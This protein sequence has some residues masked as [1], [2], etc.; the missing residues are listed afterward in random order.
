MSRLILITGVSRGLGRAL[1]NYFDADGHR[2]FGCGRSSQ[3][4][5]SL[6][7]ESSERVSLQSVDVRDD[8]A[9]AA[10]VESVIQQAGAPELL[11][12]N[13]AVINPNAPLWEIDAPTFDQVIDIN[14]KGVQNVLRHALPAMVQ[15]RRGVIVNLSSGWG[16]STSPEVAPYC[17]TKWAIEGLTQ[18]L[19]Q[20]LPEGMAAVPLNPGVIH[21]AMLESCFGAA[22]NSYEEATNW[23]KRAAPFLLGLN[24]QHNGQSLSVP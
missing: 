2:V 13:A 23:A 10:W 4:L 5:D 24:S 1:V 20:E 15:Q 17:A 3:A 12:N 21:T 8:Q 16:R 19:A 6:A 11:I 14:I 18:A 22:A 9:V 7:G